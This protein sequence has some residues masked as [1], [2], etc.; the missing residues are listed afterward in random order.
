MNE[1]GV[2]FAR[3]KIIASCLVLHRGHSLIAEVKNIS[4][5]G[6]LL[7]KISEDHIET[8]N[9]GDSCILEIVVNQSFNF[10]VTAQVIRSDEKE[11]ALHFTVIEDA[12][13]Q[14]LWQL[15]GDQVHEVEPYQG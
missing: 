11:L 15:L 7:K 13:Q 14:A 12:K 4:A 8:L 3:K 6:I 10:D 5:S 2:R 9:K 1:E